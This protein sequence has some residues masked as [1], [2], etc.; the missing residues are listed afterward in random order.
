[1]LTLS[2][3]CVS[4]TT[5]EKDIGDLKR[6][7]ERLEEKTGVDKP[8]KR[9]KTVDI[10]I[11]EAQAKLESEP[12]QPELEAKYRQ[13]VEDF[14]LYRVPS[15]QIGY[16]YCS[17]K[18]CMFKVPFKEDSEK[19]VLCQAMRQLMVRKDSPINGYG[20][21]CGSFQDTVS[22]HIQIPPANNHDR[23]TPRNGFR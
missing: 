14:V 7:L 3:S 13:I 1:M 10:K 9:P 5:Y 4:N 20:A 23:V 18:K 15:V 8:R 17:A 22:L 11:K 6:R 16:A 2:L 21:G 19:H 12:R